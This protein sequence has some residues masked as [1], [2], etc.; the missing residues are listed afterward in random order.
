MSAQQ[1]P[2]Q[3]PDFTL[4]HVL[5]HSVSFRDF[6]G[7]AVVV[8]FAGKDS[9]P[10][11]KD[12]IGAIRRR[13]DPDELPIIGVSDLQGAPRAARI[14]VKSQLKKA[15]AEAVKDEAAILEAAGKPPRADPTQDVVMLMDWSGDVVRAFGLSGVDQE[16]VA[17]A[18][19]ANGRVL[20]S[21][22]GA[23]FGEQ[24]LALLPA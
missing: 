6:S 7:R 15:F 8:A 24:I 10:Q 18:I 1:L 20:G 2:A 22:S 5:G 4:D 17:V 19:D 3:A 21:G 13:Y 11:M 16:A 23:K 9:A 12:G 14:I